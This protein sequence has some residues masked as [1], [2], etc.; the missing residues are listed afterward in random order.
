MTTVFSGP[1]RPQHRSGL[2]LRRP[3][4][5]WPYPGAGSRRLHPWPS[6]RS[7]PRA[8]RRK[9]PAVTRAAGA[10]LRSVSP[11]SATTT[12]GDGKMRTGRMFHRDAQT[13]LVH[14]FGRGLD[15]E[16][17]VV[18]KYRSH[19]NGEIEPIQAEQPR[20][21]GRRRP[22][23]KIVSRRAVR[24]MRPERDEIIVCTGVNLARSGV[25]MWGVCRGG[26]RPRAQRAL[27]GVAGHA[28][29]GS[30]EEEGAGSSPPSAPRRAPRAARLCTRCGRLPP[31]PGLKVCTGCAEKRRAADR[32]RRAKSPRSRGCRTA[33]AIRSSAG[34][35]TAPATGAAAGRVRRQG[36]C[37]SCGLRRPE[38]S[39][40]V[41]EPCRETRRARDRR[42]YDA[43]RAAGRCVRCTQ[44]TVGGLSRCGRCLALEKEHVCP[45]RV[46]AAGKRRY[47]AR[48][49]AQGACV[50]CGVPTGG[51]ARCERCA[52]RSNSRA[53]ERHLAALWPPQITVVELGDGR[54]A[55]RLRDRIRSR[56][57]HRLRQACGPTRWRSSPTFRLMALS[58]A[59]ER[60]LAAGRPKVS[61]LGDVPI[62]N[63]QRQRQSPA[64]RSARP[65][66]PGGP[67]SR[68]QTRGGVELGEG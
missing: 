51:T 57:L 41:C 15:D 30:C 5:D 9:R 13:F 66:E 16:R 17:Y 50:D 52:Y 47:V 32:A 62:P 7:R 56:R 37:T 19:P 1:F 54:G 39:R 29:Q 40:S 18:E 53:P 43:R 38:E 67:R 27:T 26:P 65:R 48:R 46:S 44:P 33:A 3:T 10:A 42:R 24:E 6:P 36:L 11:P 22:R 63:R 14:L 28:A 12:G 31:E 68:R 25:Q 21:K 49:R 64:V 4:R 35:P 23:R 55:G 20:T 45:E 61:P 8:R 60:G 59:H 34:P 58:A 2:P